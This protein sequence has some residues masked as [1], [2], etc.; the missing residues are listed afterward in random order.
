MNLFKQYIISLTL[1]YGGLLPVDLAEI[2]LAEN[3]LQ[4][5]AAE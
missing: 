1:I 3:W 5:A 2:Y 4:G